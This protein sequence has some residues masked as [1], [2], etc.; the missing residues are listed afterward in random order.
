MPAAIAK[1]KNTRARIWN[2]CHLSETASEDPETS[3]QPRRD[4]GARQADRARRKT[5]RSGLRTWTKPLNH[6]Y[7]FGDEAV[8]GL[9]DGA[10]RRDSET[11]SFGK[12]FLGVCGC[13][14]VLGVRAPRGR[15]ELGADAFERGISFGGLR[16][17]ANL[18]RSGL[19]CNG[20]GGLAAARVRCFAELSEAFEFEERILVG[21]LGLLDPALEAGHGGMA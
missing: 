6:L 7:L 8:N 20:F 3:G 10:H 19:V 15:R 1:K 2:L 21:A 18:R 4:R 12:R 17:E 11:R 14:V 5:T 9:E 13:R 16:N